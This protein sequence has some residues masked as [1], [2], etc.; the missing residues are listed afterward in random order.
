MKGGASSH[1]HA[2]TRVTH[3]RPM[4]GIL[5]GDDVADKTLLASTIRRSTNTPHRRQRH[6]DRLIQGSSRSGY[7]SLAARRGSCR[8]LA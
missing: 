2:L 1:E 4:F 7:V 6:H 5:E 8:V 3:F